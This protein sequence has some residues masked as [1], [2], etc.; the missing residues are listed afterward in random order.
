MNATQ[1]A[2]WMNRVAARKRDADREVECE[3]RRVKEQ[4]RYQIA[5]HRERNALARAVPG[6]DVLTPDLATVMRR[7]HSKEVQ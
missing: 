7:F 5:L 4:Q 6:P 1:H 3:Q 2:A